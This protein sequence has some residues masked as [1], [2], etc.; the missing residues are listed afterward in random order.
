MT[1]GGGLPCSV[2]NVLTY[3]RQRLHA[4]ITAFA[5]LFSGTRD[6]SS[7]W[8]VTPQYE[9]DKHSACH[10][11]PQRPQRRERRRSIPRISAQAGHAP[12]TGQYPAI[13]LSTIAGAHRRLHA[14]RKG[15]AARSVTAWSASA[16]TPRSMAVS[17]NLWLF[18]HSENVKRSTV[19]TRFCWMPLSVAIFGAPLRYAVWS[20]RSHQPPTAVISR[21]SVAPASSGTLLSC[22]TGGSGTHASHFASRVSRS[23]S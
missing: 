14:C 20:S 17:C 4:S 18:W 11:L 8:S 22:D 15:I 13:Q 2:A 6:T 23:T 19:F 10:P 3:P 9:H 7:S 12:H 5:P 21:A 16:S 1:S